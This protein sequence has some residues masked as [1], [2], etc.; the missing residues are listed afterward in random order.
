MRPRVVSPWTGES[1]LLED[2]IETHL[3]AGTHSLIEVI[4]GRCAGKSSALAHLASLDIAQQLH[5]LDEPAAAD[6]RAAP[7]DQLVVVATRKPLDLTRLSYRLALWSKDELIEYTFTQ[8]RNEC[9]S[10][11]ARLADAYG[12]LEGI[13]VLSCAVCDCLA[14]DETLLDLRL[15]IRRALADEV[16]EADTASVQSYATA[17]LLRKQHLAEA[18]LQD[19]VRRKVS[20]RI[21][22]V[23]GARST[24]LSLAADQI[25]SRIKNDSEQPFPS[26]TI[27][28]D[29]IAEVARGVVDDFLAQQ[30]LNA[31][32][33]DEATPFVPMVASVL[34]AIDSAWRTSDHQIQ[35]LSGG[36]FPGAKWQEAVLDNVDLRGADL[37]R[38][39]LRHASLRAARLSDAVLTRSRLTNANLAGAVAS[40]TNFSGADLDLADLSGGRFRQADFSRASLEDSTAVEAHFTGANFTDASLRMA[41]LEGSLFRG[42]IL[43][44][45]DFEGANLCLADLQGA[46][47]QMARFCGADLS[48]ADLRNC[49]LEFLQVIDAIFSEADLSDAYLTGSIMPRASFRHARL[50]RAGLAHVEWEDAD[51]RDAD[52]REC[53]FHLGSS[54]SGLVGSPYPCHGSRTGFYTDDYDAQ[55]YKAPEEIRKANLCGADLRGAMIEGADFYLVDLRGAK[56]ETDQAAYFRQCDAILGSRVH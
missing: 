16:G 34:F 27:P 21:L 23:L 13:P 48:G 51:L 25:V 31:C 44:G 47:L 30:K 36:Y 9:A 18:G 11:M 22:C 1:L 45:T 7:T 28:R 3:A 17:L 10:V 56:Y 41:N 8:H 38:S 15:A 33:D 39:D 4:G 14:A 40:S 53:S 32:I 6:L 20:P 37:S 35:T 24:K 26:T 52:F 2:V 43:E 5:L 29:L 19:L 54:R 55:P 49:N 42:A 50:N 12:L 46:D